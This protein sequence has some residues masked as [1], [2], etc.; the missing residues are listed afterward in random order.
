MFLLSYFQ[1]G[2]KAFA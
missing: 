1:V 2:V